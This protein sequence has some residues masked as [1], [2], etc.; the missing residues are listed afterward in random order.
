M[1]N[2]NA[3]KLVEAL[4]SGEFSQTAGQ[5]RKED[6]FC[7]LGVACELYRREN[8]DTSSWEGNLNEIPKFQ[9]SSEDGIV[10]RSSDWLP[11]PVREWL[12]FTGASGNFHA[13]EITVSHGIDMTYLTL[14][15]LAAMND[16][17]ASFEYIASFIE[18]EPKGLFKE[19]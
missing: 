14:A 7:C 19:D 9:I 3:Q 12:G 13:S 6:S 8:P 15:A 5:L 16:A 2:E 1:L 4:R 17:R 11:L 10:H 18:S